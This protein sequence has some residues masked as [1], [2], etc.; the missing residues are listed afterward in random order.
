MD[1]AMNQ[2]EK[3]ELMG[4]YQ[5]KEPEEREDPMVTYQREMRNRG[6]RY[7]LVDGPIRIYIGNYDYI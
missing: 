4:I 2:E 7:K 1:K 3:F 5:K 6:Y